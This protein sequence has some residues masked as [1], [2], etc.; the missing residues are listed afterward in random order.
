MKKNQLSLTG[1]GARPG[2]PRPT[3]PGQKKKKSGQIV[4]TPHDDV[5]RDIN[6]GDKDVIDDIFKKNN[7]TK[8]SLPLTSFLT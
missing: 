4:P 5:I 6:N 2:R 8:R 1:L 7:F 3:H